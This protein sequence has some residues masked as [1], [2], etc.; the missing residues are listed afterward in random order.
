[1]IEKIN[2]TKSWFFTKINKVDKSLGGLT[3]K[4]RE[5]AQINKIRKESGE[6]TTDSSEIQKIIREY[7]KNPYVNKLIT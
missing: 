3:N 1:M 5:K 4:N 2:E 7:Y 6:I